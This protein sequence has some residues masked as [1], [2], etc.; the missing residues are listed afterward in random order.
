MDTAGAVAAPLVS[1]GLIALM[2][3]PKQ[4]LAIAVIPAV[5]SVIVLLFVREPKRVVARHEPLRPRTRFSSTFWN[6]VLAMTAFM[7][8]NFGLLFL[9]LEATESGGVT[10]SLVVYAVFNVFEAG[11]A[12]PVGRWA[13]RV[14]GLLPLILGFAVAASANVAAIFVLGGHWAVLLLP[15]ALFGLARSSTESNG[16]AMTAMLAP[17][18]NRATALGIYHAATGI[19]ALPG[20]LL[21]GLLWAI[22]PRLTFAVGALFIA[23]ALAELSWLGIR[24]RI[25]GQN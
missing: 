14:G 9:L 18:A 22:D 13:D 5:L 12:Y 8:G 19:A 7:L 15:A 10:A 25:S 23:A 21:A 4:V 6:F 1:L 2:L 24:G 16:R 20:G 17:P 3:A 11:F